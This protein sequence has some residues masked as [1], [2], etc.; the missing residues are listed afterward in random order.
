MEG[1][2]QMKAGK[3]IIALVVLTLMNVFSPATAK[4]DIQVI[5]LNQRGVELINNGSHLAAIQALERALK[6]DPMY[7]FTAQNLAIAYNDY[8]L[9]LQNNKPEALNAFHRAVYYFPDNTASA[10]NL[11][12]ILRSMGKDPDSFSDRVALAEDCRR[13]G[14]LEGAIVEFLMALKIKEDL[15]IREILNACYAA[16]NT[17]PPASVTSA[18]TPPAAKATAPVFTAPAVAVETRRSSILPSFSDGQDLNRPIK[19]K[20]AVIVGVSKFKDPSI[21]PLQYPAK[22]AR[23]F[24]EFLLQRANFRPDHVRLLVDEVATRERIWTEIGEILPRLVG[25]DDLV[26]LYFSSHGSPADFDVA[27]Q[28]FLIAHD[29]KQSN[30]FPTSIEMKDLLEEINR[31]VGADRMLV[32]LDACHS[33]AADPGSKAIN[34]T[35]ALDIERFAVGRGNII[36]SSSQANERSWESQRYA[37][38]VFTRKLIDLLSANSA[39]K[40]IISVFDDLKDSVA[41]EV[42]QERGQKQTPRI[43]CDGWEG[44]DLLLCAP[45]TK[46]TVISDSVKRIMLPDS[47]AKGASN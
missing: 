15:K 36:L 5:E 12:A 47:A 17:T 31:R 40:G 21:P 11:D 24:R 6:I 37:N 13:N 33:G 35:S 20:W 4:T 29:S 23:D 34:F 27:K 14:D 8:G 2:R 26:V 39:S 9:S 30:L 22:D 38:G 32:V 45:A 1:G 43:K 41:D 44:R 19:D 3:A 10:Q 25:P 16:K 28:N 7:E 18:T 46:V 42:R